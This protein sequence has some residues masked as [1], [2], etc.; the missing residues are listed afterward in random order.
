MLFSLL[1]ILESV[2]VSL[3]QATSHHEPYLDT[4]IYK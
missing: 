2:S 3:E 1:V 4:F